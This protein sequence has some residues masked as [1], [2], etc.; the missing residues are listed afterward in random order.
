VSDVRPAA[1]VV[2]AAGEG[3]RMRSRTPKVLHPL[4]GRTMLGHVLAA[5]AP[6]A[7]RRTLV[8]VG[9][10]RDEVSATLPDGVQAVVQAKQRGTG[11]ALRVALESAPDAAG[12]V[13]VVPGD[14][15]LLTAPTL[16]RLLAVHH[17]SGAAATLL[18]TVVPDPTGY[19]RV[20]RADDGTVARIV[21]HKDATEPE[22]AVA[23]IN[24]SVY[25]FAIEP[26]RAALGKLSTD[27]AQGEEY[28]PDVVGMYV[29]AGL[30]VVAV[31]TDPAETGGVN[32]RAQLAAAGRVLRDRV[33]TGWMRAG[34]SV[35]DPATVWVDVDVELAPDVT[36]LPNVQLHGVTRVAEGAR[37]GPDCTLVDTVVGPGASV[38]RAHCDRAEIGPGATV[39]PYCYLRP[40][41]RLGPGAK[42]GTYVEI[43]AAEIGEGSKVPH[44]SYVGD[45]TIG[46]HTNIGAATVFVNYDGVAKHRTTIGDHART[47]A[48]NM[49]VAPVTV[50][51]GAYTAAGSVI[52]SD[53]P[54]GALG[55]GRARQRNIEGWVERRRAGTAAA[56]AAARAVQPQPAQPQVDQ[57]QVD[58][59]QPAQPQA[60]QPQVDQPP[61]PRGDIG[62]DGASFGTG[63]AFG[64]I[65]TRAGR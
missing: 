41:A 44:L 64:G 56:E 29:D 12:T 50:G 32:D 3:T 17:E 63:A 40:G 52:S 14:T 53:V 31:T 36:V 46:A 25:A 43:K 42:A 61:D 9:H 37:I 38:V 15:P 33:L 24:T 55:V 60:D 7:A 11:H 18:T 65:D 23:E 34:V 4:L 48:D 59:P 27:N 2:L 20:I 45:A 6:L 1:V 57:P 35:L 30:P 58:R 5:C 39:G 51:D 26:L 16:A 19:G 62:G 21:E 47:G 54:P 22:R 49:F 10:G 28:L 13:L 8:V